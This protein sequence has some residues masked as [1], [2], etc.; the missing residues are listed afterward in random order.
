MMRD[1]FFHCATVACGKQ[2]V[3][4]QVVRAKAQPRE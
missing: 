2:P 1:A 4:G 3:A